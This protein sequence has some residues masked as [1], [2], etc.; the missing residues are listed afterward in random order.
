M[1][2]LQQRKYKTKQRD[3][4]CAYLA[5][6]GDCYHNIDE[7]WSGMAAGGVKVGRSTVY[8]CLEAMARE[9]SVL[10]A[11]APNGEARYRL[12]EVECAGQ[13]VCLGCGR[14]FPLDCHMLADFSD[15]VLEHHAFAI[16]SSRTV[17]YGFC[18]TCKDQAR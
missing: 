14:A 17:L 4:V 10:K 1:E 11:I 13:L 8:R 2:P 18:D 16:D 6:H 3:A 5:N 15:H 12:V 7:V 9:G